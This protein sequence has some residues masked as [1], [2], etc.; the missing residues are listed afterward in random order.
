MTCSTCSK[1]VPAGTGT[2]TGTG[3]VCD[4][5]FGDAVIADRNPVTAEAEAFTS[6]QEGSYFLGALAGGLFG[7]L[8]LVPVLIF[9]DGRNT[10]IGAVA[11]F[12]G[13]AIL[14]VFLN[15]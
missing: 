7:C 5:C 9:A 8:G 12:V 1:T 3:L 2:Y 14:A 11:G 15:A 13:N 6:Q 10:K 4:D